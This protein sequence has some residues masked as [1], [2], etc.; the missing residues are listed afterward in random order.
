M[1][2]TSYCVLC[3]DNQILFHTQSMKIFYT[4][5]VCFMAMFLF[6]GKLANKN[7]GFTFSQ[8]KLSIHWNRMEK[9]DTKIITLGCAIFKKLSK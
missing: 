9:G 5:Y 6:G 8:M 4:D 7:E 1:W 3:S 2:I